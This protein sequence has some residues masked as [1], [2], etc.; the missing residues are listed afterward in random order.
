MG[1]ALTILYL[2]IYYLTP[3]YLF[4]PLAFSHIQVIIV[5]LASIASVPALVKS[6]FLKN[7]QSL[8]IIGLAI[9]VFLSI[10]VGMHWIG[11]GERAFFDFIP[12]GVTYFLICLHFNSK[13][14][15]QVLVV[16]LLFVC[17]FV[18]AHGYFDLVR[19]VPE[20]APPPGVA[21]GDPV[22][23][24]STASPFLLRQMI[25]PEQ[26]MLRLQGLGDINDP[27]DFGQLIVCV[28]PLAFIFWRAKKMPTNILF[29][30]LPVSVL[31]FGLFLTHS[32]GALVALAAV[33][34]LSVHR[35]IG[36]LPALLLAGGLFAGAFALNFTGGREISASAGEDRTA[37]WGQGME[38][39]KTHPLFGVG[40]GNLANYTD[41][42]LT[43]HNS[44]VICAAE[45]GLFGM[46]FWC[47][48]LFSTVRDALVVSSPLKVSQEKSFHRVDPPFPHAEQEIETVDKADVNKLGRLMVLS[49][50]GFLVA[51][52]FL[53]RAWVMTFFMLGGMVEVVYQMALQRGMVVPRL[54]FVRALGFAAGLMIALLLLL[55]I[56]LRIL[57]IMR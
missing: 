21:L 26:W 20:N 47:L 24:G 13:K 55:D 33:A 35:R 2:V 50:T 38:M 22:S 41:T 49:L 52:W 15:L 36:T 54:R 46:F 34:I 18:I 16:L 56:V 4:G 5:V 12:N 57:N 17:A 11:G 37:L 10:L 42:H 39:W 48:F 27:N 9:A 31:L 40:F 23:T 29:V 8:A 45:L 3:T 43:A 6:S 32:R 1:F 30:I 19:N 44:L 53:S 14:R 51:G 25:T 28:I 7:P